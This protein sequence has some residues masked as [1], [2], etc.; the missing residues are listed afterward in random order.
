MTLLIS[1]VVAVM[2]GASAYLMLKRDLIRVIAGMIM[3]G[4]AANLFI[5]SSGLRRGAAPYTTGSRPMA[6]PIV[7]A[8]TL[9]AIVIGFGVAMLVLVL[10]YRVYEAHRSAPRDDPESGGSS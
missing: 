10:V 7:Q 2:F 8:L 5:M 3:L 4:S 6:D 9:T 1:L